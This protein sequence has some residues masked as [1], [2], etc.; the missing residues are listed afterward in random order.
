M[1][2]IIQVKDLSK[3]YKKK[4]TKEIVKAVDSVSFDVYRG[5]I[6]GLLGPNGAGKTTTIKSICGLLVPNGGSVHINGYD[7]NKQRLKALNY[8]SAVLEGNRNIYWRLTVRENLE[9]FAGNRGVNRRHIQ[10][11]IDELLAFFDLKKK[12]TE[13]VS[14]LSRGMQQ[15][16][17]IAVALLADTDVLLLDEPTLGLDVETSYEVRDLLKKIVEQQGKTIIISSHDMP[18]VQDVCDRTVI[19]NG[20]KVVADEKVEDLIKLFD[21]R[22]YSFTIEG[23]LSEKQTRLIQNHFPIFDVQDNQVQITV[24]KEND[25][26]TMM[27]IL[28]SDQTK[29]EKIDRT[30]VDFEQ[31]FMQLI[32]K[33]GQDDPAVAS[34]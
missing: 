3:T 8:I 1:E 18:V 31:V 26:Y 20:G 21:T 10:D 4:K 11:K 33:E 27:D 15:K 5:E 24:E 22:A 19:I 14:S 32:Q 29:I 34:H 16:L 25:L 23:Q 17:A 9:Y 2:K 7:S 30:T 28:K 12:E 6:L 13:L